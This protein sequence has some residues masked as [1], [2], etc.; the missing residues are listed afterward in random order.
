MPIE[1]TDSLADH[2]LKLAEPVPL[3]MHPAAVYLSGL[4]EGSRLTIR[5]SLDAIASLL[6][7]GEC[8]ALTLD[9]SKLRY[10]HTAA[11]RAALMQKLAPSTAKK[12]LCALRRVLK[13]A[14]RLDLIDATHY[15]K[16]VD[17]PSINAD[18]EPRGRALSSEE[19]EALLDTC[20]SSSAI[21]I[22]DAALIIILR[23]TGMRRRELVN[24]DLDDFNPSTGALGIR[25]GKRGKGRTVY[26][27]TEAL[28]FVSKWLDIRGDEPG[29]LLCRIRKGGRLQLDHMH[30]D[31]IWRIITKRA[32]MAGLEPFSPHDFRRTF[33]SDLLDAGIDIVTV[34][35][36]AGHASPIQT[37]KYD[38]RG[39]ET[40][41]NA[42]Q[43]LSIPRQKEGIE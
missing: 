43:S 31:A 27:P 10:Y 21:D 13:E 15:N 26:L 14:Y 25:Q 36:L 29:P 30:P 17:L 39:E 1:Q 23:G 22:R 11:V 19:I 41:R 12:M 6:T 4:S 35:K 5:S 9:W 24:L 40:K 8:D 18:S 3:T 20:G 7:N 33:C 2:D 38:R 42:V 32:E 37:A 34:Q 28:A 16:A